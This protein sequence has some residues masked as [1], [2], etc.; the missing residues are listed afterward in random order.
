MGHI[1][2]ILS[3]SKKATDNTKSRENHILTKLDINKINWDNWSLQIEQQVDNNKISF[4][5]EEN[6]DKLWYELNKVFVE[7]TKAH[8]AIKKTTKHCKPYWSAEL[9]KLSNDL[10][11]ARKAYKKRNT[12]SIYDHKCWKQNTS[13]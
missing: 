5:D 7:S 10:R 12:D 13:H 8:G 4:D 2:F 9:T 3:M 1:P 11:L 6:P